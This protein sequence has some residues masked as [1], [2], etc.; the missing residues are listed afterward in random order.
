MWQTIRIRLYIFFVDKWESLAISA[1][2]SLQE[3]SL[4]L[5]LSLQEIVEGMISAGHCVRSFAKSMENEF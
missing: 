1:I 4:S 3:A 5:S 2:V